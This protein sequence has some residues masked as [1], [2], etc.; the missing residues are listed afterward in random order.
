M[1]TAKN[2]GFSAASQQRVELG[3]QQTALGE[4][5]A[6]AADWGKQALAMQ[7]SLLAGLVRS[8]GLEAK[9]LAAL[10]TPDDERVATAVARGA[11]YA[12]MQAEVLERAGQIGRVVDTFQHD[13]FFTGYVFQTDGT[14][15]TGYVVQL[16]VN[17][18]GTRKGLRGGKSTTDATGW[19]SIDTG[20]PATP[21]PSPGPVNGAPG[22]V[23]TDKPIA[24]HVENFVN[25]LMGELPDH[26]VAA[27]PPPAPIPAPPP[28]SAPPPP[29]GVLTEVTVFEPT[30]RAVFED[31]I[32]PDF[33]DTSSEFRVYT[34]FPQSGLSQS[35]IKRK[36]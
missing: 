24:I 6:Q 30:G 12:D 28:G 15:A 20:L 21:A 32:P 35:T 14:P 7:Q 25:R 31:P 2:A 9:R 36:G 13:G 16:V 26:Q 17:S 33:A 22:T 5:F 11:R 10:Y 23:G 19:F 4:A 29:E 34:L 3:A 27:P 1:V 8:Q 18:F